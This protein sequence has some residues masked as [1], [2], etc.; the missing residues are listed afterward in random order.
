MSYID[1]IKGTDAS[2]LTGNV[3]GTG[4]LQSTAGSSETLPAGKTNADVLSELDLPDLPLS[5]RSISVDTMLTALSDEER[6]N[7]IQSAVEAVEHQ[8]EVLETENQKKLDE[9]AK[10]IKELE[11]QSFWSKFCKVFSIIGA[12]VGAVAS[13]ATT[14]LGIMTANPALIAAGVAG[15]LMSID[16]IVSTATDGKVSLA[17][18]FTAAGKAMG[19]SDDASNW[20][21]FGMSMLVTV[22]TVATSF[23]VSAV[24]SG[25]K[26]AQTVAQMTDNAAKM[27]KGMS[28]ISTA[29]QI[30]SGTTGI[31]QGIGSAVLTVSEYKLSKIEAD[32]IDI[33]AVLEGIRNAIKM[34]EDLIEEEMKTAENLMSDVKDIVED[35]G[36]T[37]TAILTASPSAA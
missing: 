30:A 26:T 1:G 14:G 33:D 20:F 7:N 29:S 18:G 27:A 3:N 6:R 36:Q 35:C 37:A 34:N 13:V 4:R 28:T 12:V 23:G 5:M 9:I 19:M 25:A 16:S 24:S 21:G 2:L 31:A 22:V 10:Q 17:A 15:G 8:G 32:K 11:S